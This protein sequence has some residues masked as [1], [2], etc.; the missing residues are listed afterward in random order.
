M[1]HQAITIRLLPAPASR[2]CYHWSLLACQPGKER[3]ST[4]RLFGSPVLFVLF[5]PCPFRPVLALS[6]SCL[7]LQLT[8]YCLRLCCLDRRTLALLATSTC[9]LSIN[10]P[11]SF[12]SNYP[13]L[14]IRQWILPVLLVVTSAASCS[15]SSRYS[16]PIGYV[17]LILPI[18]V[19][20]DTYQ[21]SSLSLLIVLSLPATVFSTPCSP[22]SYPSG[23]RPLRCA[24]NNP[25]WHTTI[26]YEASSPAL[27]P[28]CSPDLT[29]PAV[30]SAL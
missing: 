19:S 28:S 30:L 13:K 16:M 1:L 17:V 26:L 8:L 20:N 14:N 3:S 18:L 27:T 9:R 5:W 25:P 21:I 24:S 23:R 11:P 12:V 22:S 15:R 6:T 29:R 10:C 7:L 4:A 2:F